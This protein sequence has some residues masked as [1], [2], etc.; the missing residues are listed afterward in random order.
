MASNDSNGDG[1]KKMHSSSFTDA[2]RKRG[3][4]ESFKSLAITKEATGFLQDMIDGR[5]MLLVVLTGTN[6]LMI[7]CT[8]VE[9]I[10]RD[11]SNAKVTG[12]QCTLVLLA[13][14]SLGGG[15]SG[16]N[17]NRHCGEAPPPISLARDV[18]R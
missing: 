9:D 12:D 8:S 17:V 18:K 4:Q 14:L 3:A 5:T 6:E 13:R 16:S 7:C 11:P 10:E 1:P 2:F 15:C